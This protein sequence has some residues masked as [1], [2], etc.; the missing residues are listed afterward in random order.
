MAEWKQSTQILP[1]LG[2]A[3]PDSLLP[4]VLPKI[5]KK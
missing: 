2:A 1:S 4:W 3:L 5:K